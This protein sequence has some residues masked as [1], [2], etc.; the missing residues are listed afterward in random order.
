MAGDADPALNG[1]PKASLASKMTYRDG[2]HAIRFV[3]LTRVAGRRK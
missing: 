3:R 1:A 2:I